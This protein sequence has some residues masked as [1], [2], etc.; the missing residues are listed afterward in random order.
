[1]ALTGR[2]IVGWADQR[3]PL[4]ADVLCRRC[5]DAELPH[6]RVHYWC[7]VRRDE[8]HR[9]VCAECGDEPGEFDD[10][11]D[12]P[13]DDPVDDPAGALHGSRGWP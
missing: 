4:A 5:W 8:V 1:M 10:P 7:P 11:D 2:D 13:V 12:D 9:T 3:D 6:E